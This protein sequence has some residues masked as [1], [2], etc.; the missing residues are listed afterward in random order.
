MASYT[1]GMRKQMD[2]IHDTIVKAHRLGLCDK[3]GGPTRREFCGFGHLRLGLVPFG[4]QKLNVWPRDEQGN[5]I[6]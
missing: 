1:K 2:D 5:L 6:E 3:N 4:E